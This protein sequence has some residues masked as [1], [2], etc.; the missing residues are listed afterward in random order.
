MLPMEHDDG[1]E[2]LPGCRP[3]D[4]GDGGR[5]VAV[6]HEAAGM[7]VAVWSWLNSLI[8]HAWPSMSDFDA[9]I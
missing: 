3:A 4:G 7:G 9:S 2:M 6:H 1:D 8:P 5:V